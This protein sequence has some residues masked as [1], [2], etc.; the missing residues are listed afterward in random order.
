MPT[1]GLHTLHYARSPFYC[2]VRIGSQTVESRATSGTSVA[3]R[4]TYA[5]FLDVK[6]AFD[7]VS[8]ERLTVLLYDCGIA[9]V[10]PRQWAYGLG[11]GVMRRPCFTCN[12]TQR[13]ATQLY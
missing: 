4:T 10:P 8:R 12:A 5:A 1:V 13:N 2:T 9:R 3:A 7:S 11:L 6:P